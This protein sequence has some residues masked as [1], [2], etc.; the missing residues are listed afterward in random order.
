MVTVTQKQ[1]KV[2]SDFLDILRR[3]TDRLDENPVREETFSVERLEQYAA[4]LA[5]ELKTSP[6]VRRGRPLAPRLKENGRLLLNAYL[7]LAD[8]L[9]DKQTISPAAEWLVDNFH[10][11]EDQIHEIKLGLPANYYHELP[12]LAGGDLDGYPRVYAI[13]LAIISHTDSRL[14]VDALRRFIQA[15]QQVA[16][17]CIG[18]LWA[19]PITLRIALVEHLTSLTLRVVDS[20]HNRRLAVEL[21]DLLL[22]HA[23]H[24]DSRPEDL[25][26]LLERELGPPADF[27]RAL[28]VQLI[29]QLRDQD[30]DVWP[31]FDWLENQLQKHHQTNTSQLVQMEHNRQAAAQLTVGNIITSMRLLSTLDWRTFFEDVSLVDPI[32]A[33]EA[34]GIYL[35]MDFPTRDRYRHAV[36]RIAKRSGGAE[37]EV[38]ARAVE[39][40]RAKGE[41]I[42]RYLIGDGV[43]ELERSFRYRPRL[44]ERA[45]RAAARF[46]TTLFL[47]FL[48]GLSALLLV[49]VHF[50]LRAQ[51]ASWSLSLWFE[52]L[53]LVPASE[54]ALALVNHYVPFFFKPKPLPKL[55]TERGIPADARTMVV[56]PTLFTRESVVLDLVE[57]LHIHYLG[58]QDPNIFFALLGDFADAP[59]EHMPQD[60]HL[61]QVAQRAIAELNERHAPQ[62]DPRFYL[63]HRRRQWNPSEGK[64]IGW[65]RKRGKIQEFNR[66]LRGARDTSYIVADASPHLLAQ[67]K[68]VITL[69]SDTRLPRDAALHLVGTITHPL[70]QPRLDPVTRRVTAGYGILQPRISVELVSTTQTRFAR[71]FSGNI[72]LD[73]YTTTVSDVYQDLFE[74]GSFTGKG[75]YVVDAFEAALEDRVPENTLLSHDLFEGSFAR[76]A[77]VTDV[78]LFDDFPAD[79]GTYSKRQHRW[80][81][82]DW[83]I[84]QWTLPFIPTA[85]GRWERNPLPLISRWKIFDNLRR[86]LVPLTL[87]LWLLLA[88]TVLPGSPII[89]SLPILIILLFPVYAPASNG[90]FQHARGVPWPV[91]LRGVWSEGLAHIEQ[92]I[93]STAFL[94]RQAWNQTDAILRTLYRMT[95]SRRHLLEWVTFAQVQHGAGK[96]ESAWE[97]VGPAPFVAVVTAVLISVFRPESFIVAS[98]FLLAWAGNPWVEDWLRQRMPPRGRAL[99]PEQIADFRRY[100]RR[101]WHFFETFVGPRDHW[102]A[103]DNFQEEPT[104]IVAHRTSPTNIGL[105]L[106]ATVSAHDF[107]YLGTLELVERL[108]LT[109]E[110][111]GRLERLNGHFFNWY[112]TQTLAPLRPAYISTVDSGNLAGHLLTLKQALVEARFPLVPIQ[113][114]EGLLDTLG[115][116]RAEL[117]HIGNISQGASAVNLN[118]LQEAGDGVLKLVRESRWETLPE[119]QAFLE[120]LIASLTELE[121]ILSAVAAGAGPPAFAEVRVWTEAALRQARSFHRDVAVLGHGLMATPLNARLKALT[122]LADRLRALADRCDEYA[123]SMDFRFLFDTQ[124]K[125]FVI[126]YNVAEGRRD[127]SYYDLLA[128]E[129]RLASFIAIAKGDVPQEHWFRLGRKLTPTPGG[130][131]L[132]SW[133]AT[134]F[135]YLMPVIVMRRYEGTLLDQTYESVAARQIEYGKQCRVPWGISEAGYNARDLQLNYQYGPFGVPG[136]GLKR[137]LSDDLVVSPYST[138]LAAMIVP[139]SAHAN[140]KRLERKQVFA[141]YGFYE[142]ID[143]TAER[144]PKNQKYFILRSFMAHHQGMSLVAINNLLHGNLMPDRFHAEPLVQATQRLLQEKVPREI[145]IA[146]PR[147]EEVGGDV[148]L[149]AAANAKPRTYQDVDLP[150][151]RTQLLSNGTYSV[152]VTSAGAGYSRCGPLAVTRWREDATRDH[153]GQFYYVR[154]R[155]TGQVWSTAYQPIGQKSETYE[156]TFTEDKADFTRQDGNTTTHLEIIVSTEDNVELRR[157][158]L[159]N[160]SR[161]TVEFEV[162]SFMECT[163]A[164]PADDAAHPAFSNLF[165]QT[166]F[167]PTENA[168]LATR[169]R[170]ARS[171][172]EVWG[173]H[174]LV[175]E[176]HMPGP[177]QYETDRARFLGRGHSARDPLVIHENRPLSNTVGAV[178]DPIFSL[179]RTVQVGPGET[180]RLTF[181]TGVAES[182]DEAL[183]LAD[184]YHDP[185]IFTR[186]SDLAWTKSQVQLRHL[187][188]DAAQANTYQRLAGRVIYSDPSLRPRGHALAANAKAQSGLW[189]Y[190][191]SG[192][193]PIIL[194]RISDE[195]DLAMVRELLH[196]HEYL[197]LKGLTIDFV[198]LNERAPSY[199]QTLQEELQ[200][201]IRISGSQALLDKPGGIFV[202]RSDIMPPED[203]ALLKAVARVVLNAEKG[204]LREQLRR[205]PVANEWPEAFEA[206]ASRTPYPAASPSL[207]S[208]NFFNGLGGFTEGGNQYVVVLKD[209]QWTPAPWINVIANEN[210]FGFIVS[211]TGSGYTWSANSRENRLTPWSNDAVSDP[212]GE[213]LYLRDEETG[214]YWTPT[215]LPMRSNDAYLIRHGQGYSQFEHESHG[216]S[217]TLRMFVPLQGEVK[218]SQLRVKNTGDRSRKLSLTSFVEWVL[219][220][221]RSAAAPHVVTELDPETGALLARNFYNNEFASRVA[222]AD[223]SAPERTVTG[224]RSEFLG[225]NGAA[226]RPAALGRVELSGTVGAGL[227]PCAALQTKFELAPGEERT[228]VILLG[229]AANVAEARA[230]AIRYRD[231]ATV[232]RA[233]GEVLAYWEETLGTI[234]IRTPDE[235]MNTLVNRWL[236]Y[237]V[238]ACRV[239]ARSAFYQS[240]GAFGF[241]DQL[242]DVMALVYSRPEIARAQILRAAA[243][244]FRQGDVQHWWHPPTGRGVRT[245]FSDDLIW[246]PYVTS[247]YVSVTGDASVWDE[248]VPFLEAPELELGHDDDYRQPEVTAERATVREHSARALDRSLKTGSHGLPLMGSGDWNDGMNLVGNQGQGESVWVGWFLSQAL[249]QFLPHCEGWDDARAET[250]RQH[251]GQLKLALEDQA[252]DGEWYR[253]AYFDDGTPLGSALGREC[254]IDA[255]AQSWAVL[256]GVGDPVRAQRAMAS[257][258]E[259]LVHRGDG[260]VKLF[261]PPFDQ[262]SSVDPGYIKGYLPGVRENGGQYTHAAIWT[263]MAFAELGDVDRA[264]ELFSLLNPINHT[265][266]RAGLHKYKA[267][268]Y[269]IAADVYGLWPHVGRGGWTWYTGSASWMYRAAIETLLGFELRGDRLKLRPRIPRSWRE[270][271]LTY[272]RGDTSYRVLVSQRADLGALELEAVVELD[273][274]RLPTGEIPLVADGKAH[275]VRVN[276]EERRRASVAEPVLE[277]V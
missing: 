9:R 102:L 94:A 261:T 62:G 253:R 267:E 167:L 252:W 226:D 172:A 17:L 209:G 243:R 269:V 191:I 208:L 163:L 240:G 118:H 125:L 171:E 276:L 187:N 19:L 51:G 40:A 178:L 189:A 34:A 104:P 77:L 122:P 235:A 134:M 58:N 146:S 81:R 76:S 7:T 239:W 131:A 153:W 14:D 183:R 225:R 161:T 236:P 250:Y 180:L 164:R 101:T 204:T 1:N 37:L 234:E 244:Q 53:A 217:H 107:A 39:W 91:H 55:E 111:L 179:R 205:R 249:R 65:E 99:G 32:L 181:A 84:A 154:N 54:F 35:R 193:L 201:Q 71:I 100:A 117:R 113:A 78:E 124:R 174:V 245:R 29:Q 152:M 233:F 149:N 115:E 222:F 159:V 79:Y 271:E 195:K 254:R 11:V 140:L 213:A 64:W 162:T 156:V 109:F 57:S 86:S 61:L 246:L 184:K 216:L 258:D 59:S 139:R 73:P 265:L 220:A 85:R 200:R 262:D 72:A 93:F 157:V 158:S 31:A 15:Y 259:Q 247:F 12:K 241:R 145:A 33:G 175:T 196:A 242:Q 232:D 80:T 223:I 112:D 148:F 218:I 13:A 142:S 70:N 255:I 186:E 46:P 52:A 256:S 45:F 190:G 98:P 2:Y 274:E 43:R 108:E 151:P 150:T 197:R 66:L 138:M 273:G 272:R 18:E 185:H 127:V 106:L 231:V 176:G 44:R 219:G 114:R 123:L 48:A 141:K 6:R 22:T 144:L 60:A 21:A 206:T 268:P 56:I 36:E 202:R 88:W 129:A 136:L 95:V 270:F 128:S 67:I 147:A 24:P 182:R 198:I 130:R 87:V 3:P 83:Q 119:W 264:E 105:Q 257:V 23:A 266:N 224:D 5:R 49:P 137:G 169:R 82:G 143:Y 210:D 168:L 75:L 26:R 211:E 47:G 92:A 135:E 177:V 194:T 215:P 16:P 96:T 260:L 89:W 74:E 41:H 30:P 97:R 20:R 68:Y 251:I 103:P 170:R 277:G 120:A 229:Q 238:L 263:L 132:I 227:D 166:E 69:D 203:V 199:L 207:P 28:I 110:T 90:L 214:E 275:F 237:Q 10:I 27:R 248:E 126:G 121:D 42:G 38:A 230:L 4:Y 63:F 116:L 173:F 188:I 165:V 221:Q 228:F 133:T 8:A 25:I 155:A 212:V 192:D 50:Y 160:H